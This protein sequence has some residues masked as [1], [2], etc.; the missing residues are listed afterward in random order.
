MGI[1]LGRF[2]SSRQDSSDV[3]SPDL[4]GAE[5]MCV[6]VI[7]AGAPA[8]ICGG[9]HLQERKNGLEGVAE[10]RAASSPVAVQHP[11]TQG[12]C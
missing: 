8:A 12:S 11:T 9:G 2:R 10:H 4:N 5:G 7:V 3:C 1:G 6:P